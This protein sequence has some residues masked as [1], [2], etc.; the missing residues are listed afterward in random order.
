MDKVRLV[1]QSDPNTTGA[2][3]AL[4]TGSFDLNRPPVL[5]LSTDRH[6]VETA[7]R[8]V[9]RGSTFVH[10]AHLDQAA[11]KLAELKPGVLLL[12]IAGITDVPAMLS[13]L[14]QHFP[15]LV[16][17][18]AGRRDEG[19]ELLKLTAAGGVFRFLLTPL[20]HGQTH[21]ALEAAVAEHR[22]LK[23]AG[24]R[25]ET[26]AR[27]DTAIPTKK[28]QLTYIVL[29]AAV[30]IAIVAIWFVIKTPGNDQKVMPMTQ[31]APSNALPDKPDPVKAELALAKEA[32][33]QG[34]YLEPSGESALDLYRNAL[35]LD[36]SNEAAKTGIRSVADRILARAETDLT[37]DHLEDAVRNVETARDIDPAH[38]RLAFLDLQVARERERLKLNQ[39]RDVTVRLRNLI[40]QAN[41]NMQAGRLIDPAGNNARESL[42]DA[43]RLDPADPAI[44]QG[45]R[46]LSA[47][48][49]DDAQGAL[50]A[51]K[52]REA[53]T[54]ADAARQL[55]SAGTAL[56][57]LDHA[58]AEA[59]RPAPAARPAPIEAAS[60]AAARAPEPQ[61]AIT[62]P[63]SPV[64][65]PASTTP[66]GAAP[67]VTS[68]TSIPRTREVPAKYPR[69]ALFDRIEGWVIVEFTISPSG[70]PDDFKVMSSQP[71]RTFDRAA[72]DALKQWRFAPVMRDGV[73]VEQRASIRMQ[74]KL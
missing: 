46:S 38:P 1:R 63:A 23:A 61:K 11:D 2:H 47:R 41:E 5:V 70:V 56:S 73:A 40:A 15:H 72:L 37:S 33:D 24:D 67:S 9:G 29:A 35:A 32:F 48:L 22:D 45:F 53:Q 3:Q 20:S 44:S 60:T 74:F 54:L 66:A 4:S 16:V 27:A 42:Q 71:R 13:Q 36:A 57:S 18:I 31:S 55:G 19:A 10:A 17:V 59:G 8:A 58:I 52:V 50:A 28:Y 51:G 34:H 12:D 69:E 6:L 49:I 65:T 62:P 25:R 14:K 7:Q 21:L 30:V 39:S 64:T 26:A 68:A 43:R